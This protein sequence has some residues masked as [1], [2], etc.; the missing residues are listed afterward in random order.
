MKSCMLFYVY[1]VASYSS[2]SEMIKYFFIILKLWE[3]ILHD[4]TNKYHMQTHLWIL[5]IE[6]QF[7]SNLSF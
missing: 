3:R 7:V 2:V 4:K 5:A 1:Y 6:M